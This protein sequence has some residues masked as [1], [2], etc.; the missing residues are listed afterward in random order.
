MMQIALQPDLIPEYVNYVTDNNSTVLTVSG[1]LYALNTH[2]QCQEHL[3]SRTA[4]VYLVIM[5]PTETLAFHASRASTNLRV[6]VMIAL[7]VHQVNMEVWLGHKPVSCV[8]LF[9]DPIPIQ[10]AS[11][12]AFVM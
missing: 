9:H 12:I 2:M 5:A 4:L 10:T 6:G 3:L 7:P 11:P 1:N 8:L